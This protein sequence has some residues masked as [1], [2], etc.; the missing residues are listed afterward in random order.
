MLGHSAASVDEA[1]TVEYRSGGSRTYER[2]LE[3]MGWLH[4]LLSHFDRQAI[5]PDNMLDLEGC[6]YFRNVRGGCRF[7]TVEHEATPRVQ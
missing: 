6:W 4:I 7:I 2:R 5:A 3:Q 1:L